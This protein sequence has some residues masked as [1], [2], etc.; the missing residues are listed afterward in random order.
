VHDDETL[1]EQS[2]KRRMEQEYYDK[3]RELGWR[4]YSTL[5]DM[6]LPPS[7]PLSLSPLKYLT[8]GTRRADGSLEKD[9]DVEWDSDADE[10]P[11]PPP[12]GIHIP[13]PSHCP[14]DAHSP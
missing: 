6:R 12:P 8:H 2:K 3:L 1:R 13:P 10:S 4:R 9:P 7:P 14:A 5:H 11:P